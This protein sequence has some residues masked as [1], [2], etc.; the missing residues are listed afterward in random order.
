MLYVDEDNERAV[1]LYCALGFHR[2]AA[3]V[4]YIRDD[5]ATT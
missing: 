1:R 4:S 3:D 2:H 5:R